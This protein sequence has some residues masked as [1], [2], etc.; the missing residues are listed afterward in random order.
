MQEINQNKFIDIVMIMKR[1][2]IIVFYL[3]LEGKPPSPESLKRKRKMG[4][5]FFT[6]SHETIH[7][8]G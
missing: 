5:D 3:T 1:T 7:F 2:N 4:Q 8:L 6:L